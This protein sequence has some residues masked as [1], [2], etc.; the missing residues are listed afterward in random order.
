MGTRTAGCGRS[1]QPLRFQIAFSCQFALGGSSPVRSRSRTFLVLDWPI[2]CALAAGLNVDACR[3]LRSKKMPLWLVFRREAPLKPLPGSPQ[4]HVVVASGAPPPTR[5][6]CVQLLF[7]VR[8]DRLPAGDSV[9]TAARRSSETT[10][11]KTSWPC[12]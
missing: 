12:R 5:T 6:S 11:A 4:A 8:G 9:L 7:K 3:V 2:S 10:C 1:W